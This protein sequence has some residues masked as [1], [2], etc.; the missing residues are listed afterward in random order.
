M[1]D[2]RLDRPCRTGCYFV[3]PQVWGERVEL[4]NLAVGSPAQIAAPGILQVERGNLIEPAR[5]IEGGSA[6][7]G[8]R[9]VVR[10]AVLAGRADGLFVEPLGVELAVAEARNFRAEQGR[11]ARKVLRAVLGPLLELAV[12]GGSD[13]P[14]MGGSRQPMLRRRARPAPAPV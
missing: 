10:Q 13:P 1:L 3:V 4:P 14:V 8:D 12:V 5:A 9:L 7:I 11:A 6:L 2:R